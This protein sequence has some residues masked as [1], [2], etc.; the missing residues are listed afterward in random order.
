MDV[1]IVDT[2][3]RDG[4]Q[5]PGISF[6]TKEKW[7]IV[8][9]L[10]DIGIDEIEAGIPRMGS[11]EFDF[12]KSLGRESLH[13]RVSAWSRFNLDDVKQVYKTGVNTIHI[14]IPVSY[15][16]TPYQLG[17]WQKVI[18]R[19]DSILDYSL[20]HFENVS[21]GIQDSFR[22]PEERV[23][24][25]C[26]IAQD[27]KLY[28]IRFSDTV[29]S[30]MPLDVYNL[31]LK[32]RTL[33]KG[34]IDFHGHNDLGLALGN[35]IMALE[36]GANSVNVTINGIGERAGNTP[37]EQLAFT[38]DMHKNLKSKIKINRIKPL[39]SLV[40]KYTGRVIPLDQPIVGKNA[41]TH[42]SGIHGHTLL[43]NPL[44]YQPFIPEEKGLSKYRLVVGSHSGKSNVLN[45]LNSF[46]VNTNIKNLEKFMYKFKYEARKK[47]NFLT[48]DEV[49][50][51]YNSEYLGDLI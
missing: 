37:L 49:L 10:T 30:S 41:F 21:I 13:T 26:S 15:Y 39:C 20:E 17:S 14:S 4:E 1:E 23:L 25:L 8:E 3:L 7:D 9:S 31:I 29:G 50:K 28:R 18:G 33:F 16:H 27:K 19:V 11:K 22:S 46:G 2:T 40:S 51:I 36:A 42:E 38:L 48:R 12:V 35:S 6:S 44:A 24:E 5:A 45:I 34:K 47:H 43:K 32:Y